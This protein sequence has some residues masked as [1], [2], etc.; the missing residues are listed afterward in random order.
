M[1]GS[2]TGLAGQTSG[3]FLRCGLGRSAAEKSATFTPVRGPHPTIH[4]GTANS[5]RHL[6]NRNQLPRPCCAKT[7]RPNE[8]AD[9]FFDSSCGGGPS[10][11]GSS[12][13]QCPCCKLP[14]TPDDMI[15]RVQLERDD[16]SGVHQI[17]GTYHAQCARPYLSMVRTLASITSGLSM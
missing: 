1:S 16:A 17:N 5:S 7:A 8:E 3:Y 15:A 6:R 9:M 11:D 13:P 2:T 10:G 14:I 4:G 12:R